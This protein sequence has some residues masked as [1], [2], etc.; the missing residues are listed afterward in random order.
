[1]QRLLHR[2]EVR[3]FCILVVPLTTLT[4]ASA[5]AALSRQ[6]NDH[7]LEFI[8]IPALSSVYLCFPRDQSVANKP[9]GALAK[10]EPGMKNDQ[11]IIFSFKS[12]PVGC[13]GSARPLC[14]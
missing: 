3:T 4:T 8:C 7:V 10:R 5:L 6:T 11:P 14:W 2:R 9:P 1:M 13:Q 12:L